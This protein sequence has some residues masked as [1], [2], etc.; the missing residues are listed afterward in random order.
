MPETEQQPI[1]VFNFE[2]AVLYSWTPEAYARV[3]IRFGRLDENEPSKPPVLLGAYDYNYNHPE[4]TYG[5]LELSARLSSTYATLSNP[6]VERSLAYLPPGRVE[7]SQSERYYKTLSRIT[8][9]LEKLK[10]SNGS[11]DTF[12]QF[13]LHIAKIV[14]ADTKHLWVWANEKDRVG[15]YLS[16]LDS[17]K[18][19][20]N[21]RVHHLVTDCL[22]LAG[23]YPHKKEVWTTAQVA[24]DLEGT[25]QLSKQKCGRLVEI[26]EG[27]FAEQ[28]ALYKSYQHDYFHFAG[29]MPKPLSVEVYD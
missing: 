12:G 17:F 18:D 27:K 4:R 5:G 16:R 26:D 29:D 8:K 28:I 14:N 19:S 1:L 23:K 21:S 22:A 2:K 3:F 15:C 7:L 6:I 13:V 11:P 10:Q 25:R 20:I 9:G 24:L